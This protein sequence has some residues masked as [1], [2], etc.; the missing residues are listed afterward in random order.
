MSVLA[1]PS[2]SNLL[3]LRRTLIMGVLNLTPDSFS[4]GGQY[5]PSVRRAV[6]RTREMADEGADIIDIGGES[7]RPGSRRLSAEAELKRI[8]PVLAALRRSQ[9]LK[10]IVVSIDTYKATVATAALQAGAHFINSL[11]GFTFDPKLAS[12]IAKTRCP[13]SIY[14]ILGTP[15]TM[16]QKVMRYRDVVRDIKKFF[17]RQMAFGQA[18][19]IKRSQF[20][21]DPGIGFGKSLTHNLTLVKHLGE[22]KTLRCP[23]LIGVSRKSHLG[24][25]LQKEFGLAKTP[26]PEERM[27]AG[28]AEVGVAILQGARIIRTH[29]VRET[30]QFTTILDRIRAA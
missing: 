18:H 17:V 16:Q 29:D 24:I 20:I 9:L 13:I 11:G 1:Q 3:R 5:F 7:T 19:N 30:K 15:E 8:L 22:F 21:L 10:K 23:I 2:L 12:V 28:L 6:A 25:I 14:H 4:D 27:I 26:P